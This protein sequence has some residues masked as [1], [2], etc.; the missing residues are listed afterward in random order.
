[1][2]EMVCV[3]TILM[4][5]PA[6]VEPLNLLGQLFHVYLCTDWCF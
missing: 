4:I 1:M 3:E 6:A 2:L 5:E